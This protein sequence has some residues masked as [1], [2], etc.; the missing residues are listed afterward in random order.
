MWW[1]ILV[2]W[3]A[4]LSW[5]RFLICTKENI[6]IGNFK[7]SFHDWRIL[8]DKSTIVIFKANKL[9]TLNQHLK[10]FIPCLK[11]IPNLRKTLNDEGISF[12]WK[13]EN[14]ATHLSKSDNNIRVNFF[15]ENSFVRLSK[16]WSR[17]CV[18]SRNFDVGYFFLFPTQSF[19][20]HQTSCFLCRNLKHTEAL[21]IQRQYFMKAAFN[22]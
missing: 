2:S 4:H 22:V 14:I 19:I 6:L 18:I 11:P 8:H 12:P 1:I 7:K 21:I 15:S 20:S 3:W 10:Q 9:S 5:R 17:L 13:H 16:E